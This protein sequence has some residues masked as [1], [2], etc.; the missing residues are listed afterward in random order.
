MEGFSAIYVVYATAALAGIMI[1]EACY[2]LFAGRA[3]KRTAI[4]RRMK[5]QSGKISQEQVLIQL[6]KERGLEGGVSIFSLESFRTLRTQ[7]GLIMGTPFYMSPEQAR[8][9]SID[10][11]ADV[12]SMGVVLWELTTGQRLF[13]RDNDLLILRAVTED[14]I[15]LPSSVVPNYPPELEVI[16]YQPPPPSTACAGLLER[17]CY[18]GPPATAG[19]G[20][21]MLTARADEAAATA[22]L[23]RIPGVHIH[24]TA[25]DVIRR[26]MIRMPQAIAGLDAKM[27]LQVHDEL[28]FEV[29][30]GEVDRLIAAAKDTME[31]AAHPAVTLNVH[32]AVEA[33]QGRNW[34]E[35]H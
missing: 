14:P 7:S 16:R 28:L 9:E 22:A 10:A 1:A 27:L 35:A 5:L 24:G 11:R 17:P 4:N 34:A 26:A 29:A 3:D 12:F 21:V 33:G 19:V 20:V 18:T 8:G 23:M 15:K 31:G 13:D 30:D 2:L 32:L 25:A 6:R